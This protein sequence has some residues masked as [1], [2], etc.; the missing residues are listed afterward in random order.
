MGYET[1]QV[2]TVIGRKGFMRDQTTAS[3]SALGFENEPTDPVREAE[4][5]ALWQQEVEA[6][7]SDPDLPTLVDPILLAPTRPTSR[8][9]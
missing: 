4:Y 5:L 8:R 2:G 9:R 7:A 6:Y 1:T 3:P